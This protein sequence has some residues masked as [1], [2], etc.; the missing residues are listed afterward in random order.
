MTQHIATSTIAPITHHDYMLIQQAAQQTLPGETSNEAALRGAVT[1]AAIGLML[2]G[3]LS[4]DEATDA[5]W[6]Q[7]H[8]REGRQWLPLRLRPG[9]T[10]PPGLHFHNHNGSSP[11]DVSH[12]TPT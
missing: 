12:Q 1:I 4:A 11:T 5:C 3:L 2:D 10:V 9:P 8:Q 6:Y 7:L